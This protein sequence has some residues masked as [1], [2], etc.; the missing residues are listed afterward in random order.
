M[1]T[2]LS[3]S[4]CSGKVVTVVRVV[5]YYFVQSIIIQ[6]EFLESERVLNNISAVVL[7]GRQQILNQVYDSI[8]F[9]R[10]RDDPS[11]GPKGTLGLSKNPS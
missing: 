10:I 9:N 1:T 8:G 7:N 3:H 11:L 4:V 5:F 2:F 6:Q